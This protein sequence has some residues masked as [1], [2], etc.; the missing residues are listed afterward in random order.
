[1]SQHTLIFQA[2]VGT[3]ED[4]VM[5]SEL[6]ERL[7]SGKTGDDGKTK[8]SLPAWIYALPNA[9]DQCR[10]ISDFNLNLC[11]STWLVSFEN[12]LLE[13]S[14]IQTHKSQVNSFRTRKLLRYKSL[15]PVTVY[16]EKLQ[17]AFSVLQSRHLVCTAADIRFSCRMAQT[18]QLFLL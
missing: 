10:S 2:T 15:P 3:S 6:L 7:F 14:D 8:V 5:T 16:M 11:T 9:A 18:E 4:G 17:A 13:I 12:L 1:M